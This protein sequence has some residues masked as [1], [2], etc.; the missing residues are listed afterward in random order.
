MIMTKE[1]EG[2]YILDDLF[3]YLPHIHR[4]RYFLPLALITSLKRCQ[5]PLE[6]GLR[7]NLDTE[8][9]GRRGPRLGQWSVRRKMRTET[10]Y[11]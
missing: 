1:R 7:C 6:L 3:R 5:Q 9:C 8:M 11:R 4:G 10:V 2:A